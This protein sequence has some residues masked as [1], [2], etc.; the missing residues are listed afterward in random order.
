MSDFNTPA[1]TIDDPRVAEIADFAGLQ[2]T[3]VLDMATDIADMEGETVSEALDEGV[4][5]VEALQDEEAALEDVDE[6]EDDLT[7]WS[8]DDDDAEFLPC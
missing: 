5:T 6:D 4:E 3:E 2:P 7:G 1:V 8:E